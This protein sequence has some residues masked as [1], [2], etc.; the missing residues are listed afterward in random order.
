LRPPGDVRGQIGW[1]NLLALAGVVLG[2][3]VEEGALRLDLDHW[4]RLQLVGPDDRDRQLPP[5]D[6]FLDEHP[7]LRTGRLIAKG[8]G[9]RRLEVHG[10]LDALS[11]CG[12]KPRGSWCDGSSTPPPEARRRAR[13]R[14]SSEREAFRAMNA[15]G[16]R[17]T[18]S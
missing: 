5:A 10:A 18:T 16:S 2:A 3:V 11:V 4:Q 1:T 12:S 15:S 7:G 8:V 13:S 9:D 17:S 6:P 14:C